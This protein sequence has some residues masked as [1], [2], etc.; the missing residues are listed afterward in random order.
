VLLSRRDLRK[1]LK[2]RFKTG[3]KEFILR[4]LAFQCHCRNSRVMKK[5]EIFAEIGKYSARLGLKEKEVKPFLEEIWQRSYL[6]RQISVDTYDFLHLSFQEYFTALELKEQEDGIGTIIEHIAQPW[7]EEPILLYAGICK[8]A[9]P[10]ITRIE[11]EVPE[12]IFYSNLM[13]AGKCIADAE[14]TEPGLKED[15]TQ[16]LWD[17]YQNGEFPLLI[18]ISMDVLRRMEPRGIIASLINKLNDIEVENREAVAYTLGI[19]GS[20][21]EV[22]QL[23]KTLTS[24]KNSDVRRSAAEALGVIGDE[25]IIPSLLKKLKDEEK[26]SFIKIYYESFYSSNVKDEAFEALYKISRRLGVRIVPEDG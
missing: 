11:K 16:K 18:K 10:L 17:L 4:K 2:N 3:Q 14:F 1:K 9:G 20:R 25:S 21:E 26:T 22:S 15:I 13:L 8:D 5:A 23:I 7:W 24:D 19:I 12:D 6:L